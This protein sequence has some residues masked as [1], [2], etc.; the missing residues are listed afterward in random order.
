MSFKSLISTFSIKL[1]NI[2]V[3]DLSIIT[4]ATTEAT[5]ARPGTEIKFSFSATTYDYV[6]ISLEILPIDDIEIANPYFPNQDLFEL[7]QWEIILHIEDS[8][9]L[10]MFAKI[11]RV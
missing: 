9:S 7:A 2:S 10:T 8:K 5:I 3:C 1:T 11:T 4:L 6:A